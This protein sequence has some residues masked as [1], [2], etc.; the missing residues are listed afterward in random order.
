MNNE[1]RTNIP[2]MSVGKMIDKLSIAYCSV[3]DNS[4]PIHTVPS[5]MLWGPPGVGKS[6]AVRQI[7][8][9]IE[10]KTDRK[11]VVTDVRLLLFNP[12]DLRGIPTANAEK[13]LAIWLK[14][15]IFQSP[16][17]HSPCRPQHIRS[18]LTESSEST[19]CL[20]TA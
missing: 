4:L 15:Q 17:H 16:P 20:I 3:I 5:V 6:Q 7:G 1:K 18:L 14:P 2:V 8:K 12:I 10:K 9:V 13:T 11:V 19:D